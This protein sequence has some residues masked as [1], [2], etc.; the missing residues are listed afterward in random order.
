MDAGVKLEKETLTT[1]PL[2]RGKRG[3]GGGA[4]LYII[5]YSLQ[6]GSYTTSR[7]NQSTASRYP[8]GRRVRAVQE[9][10]ARWKRIQVETKKKARRTGGGPD[11]LERGQR[12]HPA[13]SGLLGERG[14][15]RSSGSGSGS[16]AQAQAQGEKSSGAPARLA[17]LRPP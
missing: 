6:D 12:G 16:Q 5:W 14:R 10:C 9:K 13:A 4:G 7:R 15:G 11:R 1:R 17:D 8:A 2:R 3:A